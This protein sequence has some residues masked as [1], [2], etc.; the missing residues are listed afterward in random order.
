MIRLSQLDMERFGIVVAKATPESSDEIEAVDEACLDQNVEML[1]AR[2]KADRLD[3]AQSL[4]QRGA[5]LTDVL[6]YYGRSIAAERE[7]LLNLPDDRNGVRIRPCRPEEATAVRDMARLSFK[8]YSGHYHSD[9]RLDRNSCDEVYVDWAYRSCIDREVA[10]EVLVAESDGNLI[11]FGTVR[12]NTP[13]EAEGVLFGVNPAAR[14]TG[15]YRS[16]IQQSMAW[17]T[18]KGGTQVVYS[19]QISNLAVQKV[20]VREGCEPHHTYLTFHKWFTRR[21]SH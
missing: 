9:P 15:V 8:G 1:I 17:A 2:I 6:V 13:V 5:F 11:A 18:R 12:M 4:E 19:T 14:G 16:L 10:H 7:R 20:W 3:I 21:T